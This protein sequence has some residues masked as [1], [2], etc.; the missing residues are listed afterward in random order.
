M[1]YLKDP[2]SIANSTYCFLLTHSCRSENQ[3]RL[4][5]RGDVILHNV[6]LA[7]PLLSHPPA[8]SLSHQP[9][10]KY[11][12]SISLLDGSWFLVQLVEAANSYSNILRVLQEA[13][14]EILS[15]IEHPYRRCLIKNTCVQM[16]IS[17]R[18]PHAPSNMKQTWPSAHPWKMSPES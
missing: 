15:T 18:S 17:N 8:L 7:C 6:F 3:G 13:R 10:E 11:K 14:I 2:T 12:K 4:Q 5:N 16:F 1:V 9:A